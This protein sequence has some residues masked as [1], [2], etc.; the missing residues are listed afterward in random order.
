MPYSFTLSR[1]DDGNN[2]N[3]ALRMPHM[4]NTKT[5]APS[6]PNQTNTNKPCGKTTVQTNGTAKNANDRT[7]P[8]ANDSRHPSSGK[9][10]PM[11]TA[12]AH[13]HLPHRDGDGSVFCTR[14]LCFFVRVFYAAAKRT[15]R[16]F[17][18]CNIYTPPPVVKMQY[19]TVKSAIPIMPEI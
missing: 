4:R 5:S 10:F 19:Y 9:T 18:I 13:T 1:R 3:A 16:N 12:S 7:F 17:I 15:C 14:F 6:I 8:H 2:F 11:P